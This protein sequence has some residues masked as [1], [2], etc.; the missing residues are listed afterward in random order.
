MVGGKIRLTLLGAVPSAK[1]RPKYHHGRT[2][3]AS[4]SPQLTVAPVDEPCVSRMNSG[5][6]EVIDII[7][8]IVGGGKESG[9]PARM[10]TLKV[11]DERDIVKQYRKANIAVITNQS[12]ARSHYPHYP[13]RQSSHPHL[14]L[15]G[16]CRRRPRT[17]CLATHKQSKH[18][19]AVKLRTPMQLNS[20]GRTPRERIFF[21]LQ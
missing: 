15:C 5:H 10:R 14:I 4:I 3:I 6:N 11:G 16:C 8:T 21:V 19:L 9:K 18:T 7:V 13:S 2:L 1:G 20:N 17:A 12:A